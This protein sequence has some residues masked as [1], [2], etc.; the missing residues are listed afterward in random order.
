MNTSTS[1][2]VECK[3]SGVGGRLL[4]A[5]FPSVSK[6]AKASNSMNSRELRDRNAVSS[7]SSSRQT[8]RLTRQQATSTSLA[9]ADTAQNQTQQLQSIDLGYTRSIEEHY[10]LSAAEPIGTGGNGIVKRAIHKLTGLE[11]ACKTLP[12][13]LDPKKFSETKRAAHLHALQREVAVLQRLKGCLN[14][15]ELHDVF[16]D[17]VSGPGAS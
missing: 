4:T 15:V 16:E 8:H 12:K 13:V 5:M 2:T 17:E 7:T 9:S 11:F 1:S 3:A 10:V 14:V 6:W